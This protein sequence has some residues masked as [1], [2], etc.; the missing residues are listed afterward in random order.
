MLEFDDAVAEHLAHKHNL[1]EGKFNNVG[2]AFYAQRAA[3][4]D[5]S[6]PF[7]YSRVYSHLTSG[8]MTPQD[9][10]RKSGDRAGNFG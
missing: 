10:P 3:R 4:R 1:K 9:I 5:P 7:T 8:I 6:D 2:A